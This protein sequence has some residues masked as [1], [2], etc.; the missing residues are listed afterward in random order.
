MIIGIVEG[1]IYLSKSDEDFY[2][3]YVVGKKEWF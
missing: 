1:V 3:T 2:E